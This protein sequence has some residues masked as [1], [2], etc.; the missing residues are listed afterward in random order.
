MIDETTKFPGAPVGA[1][2]FLD[3]PENMP[4]MNLEKGGRVYFREG[5]N[6][7]NG[8]IV[9]VAS[10]VN[11]EIRLFRRAYNTPQ[12]NILFI[13][14]M[15]DPVVFYNP[16][17][18]FYKIV[19]VAIAYYCDWENPAAH[20]LDYETAVKARKFLDT[21]TRFTRPDNNH[22]GKEG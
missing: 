20:T 22:N 1:A 18:N 6:F 13:G 21:W 5:D 10:S 11:E 7:K 16:D 14:E 12:G 2:F 8:D 9:A 19:G 15:D 3:V 4:V 17:S